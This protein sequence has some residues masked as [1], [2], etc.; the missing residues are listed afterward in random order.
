MRPDSRKK[1]NLYGKEDTSL[2]AAATELVILTA[3]IYTEEQRDVAIADIPGAFLHSKITDFVTM[4]LQGKLTN[5]DS[6][7]C[8]KSIWAMFIY[9]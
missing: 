8:T 3:V 1:C 5:I 9:F 2:P 4:A 6:I 7:Y